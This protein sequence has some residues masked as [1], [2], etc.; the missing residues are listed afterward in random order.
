MNP[1]FTPWMQLILLLAFEVAL[2]VCAAALLQR[3]LKSAVWRRTIWQMCVLSALALACCEVTGI[4]RSFPGAFAGKPPPAGTESDD[5]NAPAIPRLVP[6]FRQKVADRMAVNQQ[7]SPGD[8]RLTS[9]STPSTTTSS[10][11]PDRAASDF[12]GDD[13]VLESPAV[14][15]PGLVWFIGTAFVLVRAGFARGLL[16][17]LRRSW[18]TIQE[19]SLP[20][21]VSVLKQ[22]LGIRRRIR[23]AES[24]RLAGPIAFG[25]FRPTIG[26]PAGFVEKFSA[27]RQEV[28]LAHELAHLAAR[29]PLWY[30]LADMVA[31]VLWWHPFI[32]WARRQL[33]GASEAAADEASLL[34]AD[35]PG[36]LA[37]CLV[38]LGGRLASPQVSGPLGVAGCRSGLGRRVERLLHL[39]GR[40]WTPHSRLCAALTQ[41]LGPAA[42]VIVT[43]LCTA[44][45]AP[46]ALTKRQAMNPIRQTWKH[47]LA[48][49]A[50]V[51]ALNADSN[52]NNASAA[53][54]PNPTT[55]IKQSSGAR[56]GEPVADQGERPASY[57]NRLMM[58]R[59]GLVPTGAAKAANELPSVSPYD[60]M[61]Q[62]YGLGAATKEK[63]RVESRLEAIVLDEVMFDGLPLAEV[64]RFLSEESRK[65]DPEKKG[66]NFLINP[67]NLPTA[68]AL[69]I[70]PTT[71]APTPAPAPEPID[72]NGVIVHFNLPLRDV[73]LKDALDAVVKV[74]DKPLEYSVEEYGVVFSA[75][76]DSPGGSMPAQPQFGASMPLEVRTFRVETNMF[77]AGL[78]NAFGIQ[79]D[80]LSPKSGPAGAAASPVDLGTLQKELQENEKSLAALLPQYRDN[81]P[82]VVKQR[83]KI[84]A[85]KQG[86]EMLNSGQAG[87]P[88]RIR[89]A[90]RQL[91]TQLGINMDLPGK[92]VFYN[93]LTG[94]VMVRATH[95]DLEIVRAAIETLGGSGS[96]TAATG[97]N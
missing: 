36:V 60:L 83:S 95:E 56:P 12:R 86:I 40:S 46:K 64:L 47:S 82:F 93:D 37:E 16:L 34:V 85:L 92:T 2:V 57:Y 43:I 15:W 49:F 87:R 76:S 14:L 35:G 26:L 63:S 6:E 45:V 80:P 39:H 77:L 50:L 74:A 21:R 94:I 28:M 27:S 78:E 17:A 89:I 88:N 67:N 71:G 51:T 91:M 48:A 7:S 97:V 19:E 30:L 90:L 41:S 53:E 33:H 69:T 73:R 59:Y 31:A 72:M 79:L 4:S 38:E 32:W 58:E 5:A 9:G 11:P 70:D 84:A 55:E 66:I 24:C 8:T 10:A 3:S 23:L 52:T 18:K 75:N 1:V 65:R 25:L 54:K 61:R 20:G 81:S 13:S 42:L 96:E 29:D 62:R 68:Q 44:W 22:Q